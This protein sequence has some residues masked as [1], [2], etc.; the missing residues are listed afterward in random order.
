MSAP[1]GGGASRDGYGAA[2]L[3]MLDDDNLWTAMKE[4]APSMLAMAGMFI[5]TILLA[6]YLQPFFHGAGLHAFGEEGT[7]Q[8]RYVVLELALIFA[9]TAGILA[10]AKWKKLHFCAPNAVKLD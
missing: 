2:L 10:L 3:E 1:S 4:Q 6:V 9:F 7:S 5:V 8:V